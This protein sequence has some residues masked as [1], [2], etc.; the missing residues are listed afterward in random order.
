MSLL[1]QLVKSKTTAALGTV[2]LPILCP[3]AA[4]DKKCT[5]IGTAEKCNV[6]FTTSHNFTPSVW[7]GIVLAILANVFIFKDLFKKTGML[8]AAAFFLP[9]VASFLCGHTEVHKA[10]DITTHVYSWSLNG[11]ILGA[12]ASAGIAWWLFNDGKKKRKKSNNKPKE[13]IAHNIAPEQD[14]KPYIELITARGAKSVEDVTDNFLFEAAATLGDS[15]P[16]ESNTSD[17]RAC[18]LLLYG[19]NSSYKGSE[20]FSTL[21]VEDSGEYVHMLSD[22]SVQKSGI[23]LQEKAS[24]IST[25]IFAS[26]RVLLIDGRFTFA[27]DGDLQVDLVTLLAATLRYINTNGIPPILSD[28]DDICS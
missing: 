19:Y 27:Q 3:L 2:F 16:F 12:F 9:F 4:G 28:Q 14:L 1:N 8:Y 11:A 5:T 22:D 6:I 7:F 23:T 15:L 20:L 10:V 25:A 18:P 24:K 13:G 26:H 21:F 17:A